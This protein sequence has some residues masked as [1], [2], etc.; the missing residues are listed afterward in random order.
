MDSS[1]TNALIAA[2]SSIIVCFIGIRFG[3]KDALSP[4]AKRIKEE[5]L[6]KV[7]SP[8]QKLLFF[9]KNLSSPESLAVLKSIVD[10]NFPLLPPVLLNELSAVMS[11]SGKVNPNKLSE[12]ASSFYNWTRK[13]LGY[14]YSAKDIKPKLIP[15][16]ERNAT[17]KYVVRLLVFYLYS[18]MCL[19][20]VWNKL[21]T[22]K[23]SSS[24]Q[25]LIAMVPI[26]VL[27]VYFMAV[28]L[29]WHL[30]KKGSQ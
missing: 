11:G 12:I 22:S 21:V 15:T 9:D 18:G 29:S 16:A 19:A 6:Q 3:G 2:A 28:I 4:S 23:F 24:P 20:F 26:F 1:V 25:H 7:F 13:S 10:E 14:P 30:P 27:C 8:I 5:Q 17:F